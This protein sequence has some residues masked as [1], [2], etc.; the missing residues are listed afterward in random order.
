MGSLNWLAHTTRSDPSTVVSLLAQHQS[1]P[2]TGHLEAA[3]YATK[4]LASTKHF[5]YT[6]PVANGRVGII[7]KFSS[8][9]QSLIHGQC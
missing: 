6:L 1:N 5:E 7:F 3:Y 9:G 8:L 2:S 4:Y